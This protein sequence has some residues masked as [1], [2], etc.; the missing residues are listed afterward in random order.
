[1][2]ITSLKIHRSWQNHVGSENTASHREHS[3]ASRN[4]GEGFLLRFIGLIKKSPCSLSNLSYHIRLRRLV[5]IFFFVV[6]ANA[7]EQ[8]LLAPVFDKVGLAADLGHDWVGGQPSLG[9][10]PFGAAAQVMGG[11][12]PMHNA[13]GKRASGGSVPTTLIEIG[14]DLRFSVDGGVNVVEKRRF[15]NPGTVK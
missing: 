13:H 15:E 2:Q 14:G 6:E 12:Q 3:A 4:Q 11:A 5:K 1:L 8:P 7:L 10:Q 9:A